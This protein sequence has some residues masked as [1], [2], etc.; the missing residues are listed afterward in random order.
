MDCRVSLSDEGL[1]RLE[2]VF[3][4]AIEC[5][6]ER[7]TE[8]RIHKLLDAALSLAAGPE[9][10][11]PVPEYPS[12]HVRQVVVGP[13]RVVCRVNAPG[14]GVEIVNFLLAEDTDSAPRPQYPV[15]AKQIVLELAER[16]LPDATLWDVICHLEDRDAVEEGLA[17]LERGQRFPIEAARRE[18]A[19][20]IF[21]ASS[22]A[23]PPADPPSG[24][25]TGLPVFLSYN[26]RGDLGCIFVASLE[27]KEPSVAEAQA[28]Q[29]VEA[30]LALG[31]FP[32]G[33]EWA[34]VFERSEL[35]QT[36]IDRYRIIY[37]INASDQSVEIVRFLPD[38]GAFPAIP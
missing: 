28:N 9:R 21:R 6:G 14:K 29:F 12:P 15:A 1:A 31:Q 34:P 7:Q 8:R 32:E 24:L 22:L 5:E 17:S 20:R 36:A 26:A 37:R 19:Q 30:A 2:E 18:M 35:R 33:G 23:P 3:C 38:M 27:E 16:L 11:G 10:S 13:V 25:G 4:S